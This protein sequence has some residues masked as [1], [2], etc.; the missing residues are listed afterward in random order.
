MSEGAGTG[1]RVILEPAREVPVVREVDVLVCGGGPAGIGAALAAARALSGLRRPRVLLV[2][3]YGFLGGVGTAA[4]VCSFGGFHDKVRPV[5]GGV[6]GEIRDALYRQGALVRTDGGNEAY[7]P[8]A[9]KQLAV[10]LLLEAGVELL[11][12]TY[13]VAAVVDRASGEIEAVLV[14]SKSGRQAIVARRYVDATGDGDLAVRAGVPYEM[15]RP[16]DGL[17]QP[18]T[19]MYLVGGVSFERATAAR[20]E[21]VKRDVDGRPYFVLTGLREEVAAARS[22]GELSIPRDHVSAVFQEPWLDGVCGVN[23]GRVLRVD[24]TSAQDLTRAEIEG[25]RQVRDGLAFLKRTVPGFE[26]AEL[27]ITAPQ[28]GIRESRRVRGR[29]VMTREDITTYRQFGDVIAQGCW[30]LDIHQP[31]SDG[32]EFYRLPPGAHY[33]IPYG[34]LVPLGV[35]NLLVA[36]RCISASHEALGAFRIQ[37]ICMAIGE[38][39]G[40]AASLSLAADRAPASLDVPCLQR[41]LEEQGA[42]LQ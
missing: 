33:D 40:A 16:S 42:I 25:R 35:H 6:F 12:H 27:L 18:P 20:P 32:T 8:E 5:I 15:G 28:I 23:Y 38:A 4:L 14:E 1:R 21:L 39:A 30:M 9:Y 3:R 37:A 2:E 31:D 41:H 7:H 24:G 36:G 17:M 19:M 13:V 34:S 26:R 11:L 29:Y 22:V 10:D